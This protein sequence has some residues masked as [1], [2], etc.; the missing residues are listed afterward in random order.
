MGDGT[1]PQRPFERDRGRGEIRKGKEGSDS[2]ALSRE[3]GNWRHIDTGRYAGIIDEMNCD[4]CMI[5]L[6][7]GA[8]TYV[9]QMRDIR[10]A[11]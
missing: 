11:G 3:G 10:Q 5:Q 6:L 9:T 7:S 2:V 1:C 8:V 4:M